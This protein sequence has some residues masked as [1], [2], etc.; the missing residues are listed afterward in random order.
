MSLAL[1]FLAGALD[2]A[3]L[4]QKRDRRK[5]W[6]TAQPRWR[7]FLE[8]SWVGPWAAGAVLLLFAFPAGHPFPG[9]GRLPRHALLPLLLPA[10]YACCL[11]DWRIHHPERVLVWF[12]LL[13]AR[14]GVLFA[15]PKCFWGLM[16]RCYVQTISAVMNHVLPPLCLCFCTRLFSSKQTH[17]SSVFAAKAASA[18]RSARASRSRSRRPF[19][20]KHKWAELSLKIIF[21]DTHGEKGFTENFVPSSKIC[22]SLIL[23]VVSNSSYLHNALC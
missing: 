23:S 10:C 1:C 19:L 8:P 21:A 14:E 7:P 17:L 3:L 9:F 18:R 13:T 5:G 12:L 6:E 11:P 20:V 4:G 15:L 2:Q 22:P 16:S